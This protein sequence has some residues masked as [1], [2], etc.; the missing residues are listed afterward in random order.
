VLEASAKYARRVLK[1]YPEALERLEAHLGGA[2]SRGEQMRQVISRPAVHI[3]PVDLSG[4]A[5]VGFEFSAFWDPEHGFGVL[6]H[7][8]RV[9]AI[10]D[11]ETAED[12]ATAEKDR[13]RQ[14]KRKQ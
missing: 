12:I 6:T 4:R 14:G 2:L 7:R 11:A 13:R 8:R 9:V 5:Y 3:L 1:G 10:D